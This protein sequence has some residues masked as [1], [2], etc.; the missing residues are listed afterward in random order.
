VVAAL[1]VVVPNDAGA[2][3]QVPAL[4]AAARGISR[5]VGADVL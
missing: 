1:S 5:A 2:R 4:K 3:A